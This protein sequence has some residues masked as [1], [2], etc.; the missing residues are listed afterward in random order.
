MKGRPVRLSLVCDAV[1]G[2][3]DMAMDCDEDFEGQGITLKQ[4]RCL[5][6]ARSSFSTQACRLR[7][8]PV[9]SCSCRVCINGRR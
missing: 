3:F 6:E 1:N 8:P 4:V 9:P 2:Q 5:E 7:C